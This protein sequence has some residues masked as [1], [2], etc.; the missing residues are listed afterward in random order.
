MLDDDR[1]TVCQWS[2]SFYRTCM[3]AMLTNF[4][5]HRGHHIPPWS[6]LLSTGQ[7]RGEVLQ[8]LSAFLTFRFCCDFFQCKNQIFYFSRRL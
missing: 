2:E 5:L 1:E 3:G 6:A 8:P 4:L 7:H